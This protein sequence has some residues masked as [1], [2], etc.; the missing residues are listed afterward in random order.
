MVQFDTVIEIP[1]LQ[2]TMTFQVADISTQRSG[3]EKGVHFIP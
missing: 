2:A 1:V 3:E